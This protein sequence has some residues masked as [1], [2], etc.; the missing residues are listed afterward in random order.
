MARNKQR[1]QGYVPFLEYYLRKKK[2]GGSVRVPGIFHG[3]VDAR[4]RRQC[5]VLV[6][7]F[8]NTDSEAAAAYFGFRNRQTE[9]TG[10]PPFTFDRYFGELLRGGHIPGWSFRSALGKQILPWAS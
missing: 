2:E 6:H 9:L 8:N 4:A 7:G 5:L 10:A 3:P 1:P